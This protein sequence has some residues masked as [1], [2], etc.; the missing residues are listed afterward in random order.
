MIK[1][2]GGGGGTVSGTTTSAEPGFPRDVKEAVSKC[3]AA[4]QQALQKRLSR[5]DIE[6][7]VGTKFGVEKSGSKNKKMVQNDGLPTLDQLQ[8]SDREL[9]R[10]FVEMFQPLGGS[11]ISV[12]FNDADMAE[13][14]KKMWKGDPSASSCVLSLGRPK[15]KTLTKQ[16]KP[17]GFAAKLAAEVE[18]EPSSG[19]SGGTFKLPEG[20]ELALF[21]AP[22]P[23][24]LLVIDKICQEV[25]MG[26][27]VIL[28]NARLSSIENFGTDGAKSR[29]LND[30][31]PVFHLRA[32]PQ[33]EAPGCLIHRAYPSDWLLARKPKVGQPKVI[34]TRKECPSRDQ[35]REAFENMKIGDLEKGVETV[36]D[37]VAGWF[38]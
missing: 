33:D 28:L 12:V 7:P 38:R 24:E 4:V 26:T 31:E 22:G 17:M 8:A 5:M 34:L 29:F 35:C 21:V 36:L 2:G 16:K 27:L 19:N 14:A 6:M 37:G 30:F 13:M 10:I 1:F 9:A 23:K 32:A 11:H 25:G 3:R 18:D 15:T 20:T